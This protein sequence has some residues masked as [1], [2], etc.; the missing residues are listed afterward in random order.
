MIVLGVDPGSRVTG[1]GVIEVEDGRERLVEYGVIR[2][3]GGA[4]ERDDHQLRLRHLYDRLTQ[5]IE[6]CLPD[7]CAVEMP[8]Y[9]RN[10]QS[11]LKLGRA[12]AAIMLAA[13]NREVP[14]VEYPP[15]EVKKSVTGQGNATKEQVWYMVRAILALDEAAPRETL[16]ASDALAVALC[17]AGRLGRGTSRQPYKDWAGFVRAHPDRIG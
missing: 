14:V 3:T 6:R 5:V 11:M 15:A 13:L 1:Y 2:L 4:H 10:P 16:D 17:H 9:G 8:V 7:A 12:Q